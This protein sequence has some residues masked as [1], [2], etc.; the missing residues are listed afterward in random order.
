MTESAHR[1]DT[2]VRCVRWVAGGNLLCS[3]G[4]QLSAPDDLHGWDSG[5]GGRGQ[6]GGDVCVHRA[7][8]LHCP[9]EINTT[10]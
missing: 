6:E 10:P 3:T 9:A 7:D 8:S 2:C 4:A 5:R 1:I